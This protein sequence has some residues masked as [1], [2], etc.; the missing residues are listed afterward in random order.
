ME[1][2]WIYHNSHDK[3]FRNPFG[4]VKSG[5][6]V[7]LKLEINDNINVECVLLRYTQKDNAFVTAMNIVGTSKFHSYSN[8]AK[9]ETKITVPDIK[10]IVWYYFIVIKESKVY[11]YG[12]NEAMNGGVGMISNDFPKPYQ[13]TVYD[14]EFHT[15]AWIRDDIMYHIFLDRFNRGEDESINIEKEV[16]RGPHNVFR[17]DWNEKPAYI[18]TPGTMNVIGYD[19]YGGN[20][21]GVI[22]KLDYLQ[23]LNVGV[24]YFSPIFKSASNHGYDTG[25]YLSVD[26]MFGTEEKFEELIAKCKER[27]IR[28]ILDGVF[29]HT[30]SDSVYFNKEGN[31][32]SVGAYNSKD[33]PYYSWY[34]FKNYPDDYD[35]WWGFDTLPN[36][37]EMNPS[38]IDFISRN[39]D[40]V[41]K[42]WMKKGVAGWRLDVADE[43]PD[44]FIEELRKAVKYQRTNGVLIG[45]V[46]EDASNKVS[47]DFLREY[48]LGTGLDSVMNY[49]FRQIIVD[50][51]LGYKTASETTKEFISLDENYPREV[52]YAL[53]NL[54]GSHDTERILTLLGNRKDPKG[55]S[56]KEIES[57]NLGPF[58]RQMASSRLKLVSLVQFTFP[59]VPCIY[60]GDEAGVEGY[61][62]PHNRSTYPWGKESKDLLEWYKMISGIRSEYKCLR[63]GEIKFYSINDDVICFSRSTESGYDVFGE[64]TD[65]H[66]A[67]IFINRSDTE[68]YHVSVEVGKNIGKNVFD[69]ILNDCEEHRVINGSLEITLPPFGRRL[70][71]N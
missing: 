50:F 15:P 58:Q 4:A 19:F 57:Y 39:E 27:G 17:K 12:N 25:D 40:S 49:P 52:T 5:A 47:Y 48:I 56:L 30:G 16:K 18:R 65:A 33:S 31:Y 64:P 13:L 1:G 35:A 54:V 42:H 36:V 24:I 44:E 34:K 41:I 45:E 20:F 38:Y 14:N 71:I 51:I 7:T 62:D 11:Y 10:G 66:T 28:I 2:N 3:E 6:Q 53:M 8:R 21:Q 67:F 70:L 9:Y 59:G 43:L 61:A 63:T 32:H 23:S 55:M 26:P 37:D 46:W 60:Y 69:D 29:S 68:Y 22:D